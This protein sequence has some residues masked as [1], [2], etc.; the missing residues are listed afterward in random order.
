[1]TTETECLSEMFSA[2]VPKG[3]VR[4]WVDDQ[5]GGGWIDYVTPEEAA[6]RDRDLDD[7][8]NGGS[9]PDWM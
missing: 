6:D 2:R 4:Y 8:D 3:K 5:Q 1:M 7:W 9:R